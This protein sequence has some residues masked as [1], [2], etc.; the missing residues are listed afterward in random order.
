MANPF[1][2]GAGGKK[3]NSIQ[4]ALEDHIKVSQEAGAI[5]LD[6]PELDDE[7][8]DSVKQYMQHLQREKEDCFKQ[9]EKLNKRIKQCVTGLKLSPCKMFVRQMLDKYYEGWEERF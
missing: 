5:Q 1:F 6:E 2:N 4:E 3:F 9:I 7:D 8:I